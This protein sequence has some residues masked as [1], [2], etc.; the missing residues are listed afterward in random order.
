M[1]GSTHPGVS[2]SP[3]C[4]SAV[5]CPSVTSS[6]GSPSSSSSTGFGVISAV[7][8]ALLLIAV[9]GLIVV[10][11]ILFRC[12]NRN[13]PHQ[14]LLDSHYGN[15]SS[16]YKA[17]QWSPSNGHGMKHTHVVPSASSS[18]TPPPTVRQKSSARLYAQPDIK[19]KLSARKAS[20]TDQQQNGQQRTGDLPEQEDEEKRGG[21]GQSF[22]PYGWT[23]IGNLVDH[24]SPTAIPPTAR[25]SRAPDH[26]QIYAELDASPSCWLPKFTSNRMYEEAIDPKKLLEGASVASQTTIKEKR[27]T[28]LL[29]LYDE[30]PL[31]AREEG[32][33]LIDSSLIK[34]EENDKV[35][36]GQFGAV[37]ISTLLTDPPERVAIKTLKS[38]M[39]KDLQKSFEKEVKF[40]SRLRHPH[41]VH[42]LGICDDSGLTAMVMENM[43]NGDLHTYLA[44]RHL[45][46]AAS[47]SSAAIENGVS[48]A[49]LVRMMQQVASGMEY[50]SS[51][52]F[53]HRDLAARNCLV[54]SDLTIK[55]GDFG[56]T[57]HLYDRLYYRIVGKAVLPLQWMAPECFYGKF[58]IASDVFSFGVTC[59]EVLTMCHEG[60]FSDIDPN[61][62]IRM[63][64]RA[65]NEGTE[66][67][68]LLIPS[69]CPDGVEVLLQ[70]CWKTKPDERPSFGH[71]NAELK[72]IAVLLKP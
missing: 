70:Q 19:H 26:L 18:S 16:G 58:S 44:K 53:V 31:L 38:T 47:R 23:N 20:Q 42:L 54:G 56:L 71:L 22:K 7:L 49:T 62:L 64:V 29:A 40:M 63:T 37:Y 66:R 9:L 59:W 17:G 28:R 3:T 65:H 14:H 1:L 67:Q 8:A 55:L 72:K 11:I 32:P 27:M 33:P 43:A 2:T 36:E 5:P 21:T 46:F 15:V 39:D 45:L 4:P 13:T 25:A 52:A 30:P 61:E 57:C 51:N 35:G 24:V 12:R 34:Y 68:T 10:I 48:L 6:D 69:Y 41:V 50:L 60:P